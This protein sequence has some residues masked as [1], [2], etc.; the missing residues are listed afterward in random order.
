[1]R[2]FVNFYANMRLGFILVLFKDAAI[3]VYVTPHGMIWE[4]VLKY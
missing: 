4:D 2:V 1:V 3:T